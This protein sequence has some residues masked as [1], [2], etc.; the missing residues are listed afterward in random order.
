M[1][2]PQGVCDRIMTRFWK[3][4]FARHMAGAS[5]ELLE[6]GKSLSV[7]NLLDEV[8]GWLEEKRGPQRPSKKVKIK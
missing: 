1:A 7:N 3:T 5:I 2:E 8:I 6:A 4:K